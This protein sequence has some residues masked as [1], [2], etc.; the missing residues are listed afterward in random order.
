M[1]QP[2]SQSGLRDE[3]S[4]SSLEGEWSIVVGRLD[5]VPVEP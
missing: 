1:G 2:R 3:V 4:L 5:V